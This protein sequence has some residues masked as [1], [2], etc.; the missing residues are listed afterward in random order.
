MLCQPQ[1]SSTVIAREGFLSA[2]SITLLCI[3]SLTAP[4]RDR[5]SINTLDEL[6]VNWLCPQGQSEVDTGSTLAISNQSDFNCDRDSSL[7]CTAQKTMLFPGVPRQVVE[8]VCWWLRIKFS[9]LWRVHKCW[10]I[11]SSGSQ[12]KAGVPHHHW[13]AKGEEPGDDCE[14]HLW[15]CGAIH[16]ALHQAAHIPTG[17]GQWDCA[18]EGRALSSQGSTCSHFHLGS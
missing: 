11:L 1:V 18:V 6:D 16:P 8:N 10:Y 12:R 14:H 17:E 9:K 2:L 3:Q 15:V 4:V 7:T 5:S 13:D